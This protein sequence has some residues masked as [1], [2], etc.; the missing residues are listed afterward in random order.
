VNLKVRV[1]IFMF[2]MLALQGIPILITGYLVINSIVYDLNEKLLLRELDALTKHL[3]DSQQILVEAGV[4]GLDSYIQLAQQEV[5][6]NLQTQADDKTSHALIFS[7]QGAVLHSTDALTQDASL[8][9]MFQ[10]ILKQKQGKVQFLH[11]SHT[12]FGVYT[13]FEPWEWV[14]LIEIKEEDIFASRAS[15]VNFV[16]LIGAVV[17]LS[18]LLISNIFI[19]GVTERI[20]ITLNALKQI[21]HGNLSVRLAIHNLDEIGII[22]QGINAMVEKNTELYRTLEDKV[23]L[24]TAEL[25]KANNEITLLNRQ[26]KIENVRMGA[27]LDITRQLQQMVLPK[28]I[29]LQQFKE[30][31]I[32]GF[33]RPADEVGG[34]YYDVLQHDEHIVIGIGDVTGHGLESGVVMLMVQT[35]VRGLLLSGEHS[36]EK[37]MQTV[38]QTVYANVNRIGSDKSLTLALLDYHQGKLTITGQ[39][40]QVLVVRKDGSSEWVDT[41][42]LGYM[43]GIDEDIQDLIASTEIQLERGDG[44][45]LYTDGITE[46]HDAANKQAFYGEARLSSLIAHH[47]HRPVR[48]ISNIVVNDV[49]QYA[50]EKNIFDDITLLILRRL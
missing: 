43:L 6:R 33:M 7:K 19:R 25:A 1:N 31:E 29:E 48:E 2:C 8:D 42:E 13:Y 28:K 21:E 30:F 15:Y 22:Q 50:G 41:F 12:H 36:L 37:I 18:T 24:R 32:A 47:W 17:L 10:Q 5:L 49:L 27:E 14:V 39:H 38:N 3:Q 46:A 35:L 40:E 20:Q 44:I 34:D 45:I 9:K 4:A 26:L 23:A 11:H 16:L